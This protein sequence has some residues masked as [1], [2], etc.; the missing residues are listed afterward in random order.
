MNTTTAIANAPTG[1]PSPQTGVILANLAYSNELASD[2]QAALP[3]WTLEWEGKVTKDGN[4]AFIA[5][6]PTG[7]YYGLAFRGS[8]PPFDVLKDWNAF[9]NWVLEDMDVITEQP[10]PYTSSG[11]GAKISNGANTAFNNIQKMTNEISGGTTDSILSYLQANAVHNNKTVIIAGHSL[12]GNM[13]NVYAS[14]FASSNAGYNNLYLYTYAAPAAGNSDFS[15]DLDSK[16]TNAWH[17]ENLDDIV[18]KFPVTT[19]I[20]LGAVFLYSPAPYSGDITTTYKGHTVSLRDGI[21]LLAGALSLYGYTRQ[22]LNYQT[23]P[24]ALDSSYTANTMDDWFEQAGAQHALPNYAKYLGVTL[25]PVS[26]DSP[27]AAVK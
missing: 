18:P 1:V 14:Y 3:G 23:F 20:I 13:A 8:L 11:S 12:G 26:S 19:S 15:Q 7:E 4:T 10:W 22:D 9:A 6:D 21:L 25:Q 24:N 2:L 16:I 27:F 17:Y 5:S